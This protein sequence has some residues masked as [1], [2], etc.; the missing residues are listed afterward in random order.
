MRGDVGPYM[1][2]DGDI[3]VPRTVPYLEARKVARSALEYG[4]RLKYV[5]KSEVTLFSFI[6]NCDCDWQCMLEDEESGA[7][8]VNREGECDVP[9][10]HFMAVER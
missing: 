9:A 1:N 10:W 3:W 5:G 4:S 2:D 6:N 8:D 7:Y